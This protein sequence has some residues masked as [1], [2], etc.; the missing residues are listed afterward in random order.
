MKSKSFSYSEKNAIGWQLKNRVGSSSITHATIQALT[1]VR[2]QTEHS[3][4]SAFSHCP[5]SLLLQDSTLA[6]KEISAVTKT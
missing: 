2:A 3:P 6:M 4:A 5:V 1:C